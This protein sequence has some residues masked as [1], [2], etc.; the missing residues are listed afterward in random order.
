MLI[1]PSLS[2]SSSSG[3]RSSDG[4][5]STAANASQKLVTPNRTRSLPSTALF[6]PI[7]SVTRPPSIPFWGSFATPRSRASAWSKPAPARAILR[8]S[9]P[10][11]TSSREPPKRSAPRGSPL[12]LHCSSAPAKPA[13]TV[14]AARALDLWRASCAARWPRLMARRIDASLTTSNFVSIP[15]RHE[16]VADAP[17]GA[18]GLR[19]TWIALDLAAQS[20]H[21]QTDRPIERLHLSLRGDFEQ[22]IPVQRAIGVLGKNSE[23]I[24]FARGERFLAAVAWIDKDALLKVENPPAQP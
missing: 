6:W 4:Y 17:H 14:P 13:T 2:A 1:W 23:K 20:C 9:Q 18:D 24:I 19:P 11:L 12:Q 15:R 22:P 7:G 10:R 5:P 16:H 3:S 21:P 8:P